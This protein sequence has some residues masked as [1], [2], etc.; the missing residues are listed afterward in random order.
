M[1]FFA[2]TN[3]D[4]LHPAARSKGLREV[5]EPHAGNFRN[6]NLAAVHLL[7]ASDH[8]FHTLLEGQPE[9]G[10]SRIG[11]RNLPA[12]TLFEENRDHAAVA[13]D[14]VSVTRATEV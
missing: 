1:Q 11:D 4:V 13:A 9:S 12:P 10:H 5:H 2:G 14:N 6:K 8:K 7:Q 3:P